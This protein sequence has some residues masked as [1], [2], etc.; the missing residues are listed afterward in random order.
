MQTVRENVD[1]FLYWQPK[2]R[3]DITEYI[4]FVFLVLYRLSVA[5]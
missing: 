2:Q 4:D 3:E 1:T 5:Y